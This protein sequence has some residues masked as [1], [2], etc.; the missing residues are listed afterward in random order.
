MGYIYSVVHKESGKRYIGQTINNP[1]ARWRNHRKN[2]GRLAKR[3][4]KT[5]GIYSRTELY[6]AMVKD[7]NTSFKIETLYEGVPHNMLDSMEIWC[8]ATYNTLYPNGYNVQEG[9][10]HF[11]HSDETKKRMSKIAKE[12]ASALI[13]KYRR[14]DT[15]GLPM[16]IV[17]VNKKDTQGYAINM[18]PQCKWKSF[19]VARYKSLDACKQ[20]AIDFL[21]KLEASNE[22]YVSEG[23]K[24]NDLPK[25]IYRTAAGYW[26]N[27]TIKKV[28]HYKRFTDKNKT[29]EENLA[30]AI[31]YMSLVRGNSK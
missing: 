8:I 7:G 15:K 22:T 24:D 27:S 19:T 5:S 30:D 10:G 29:D 4:V 21:E 11:R 23:K 2:A 9:G 3:E 6:A 12:Q 25:G 28:K 18:H 26:I 1:T 31:A 20:A 17:R 14:D 16:Y 13:D